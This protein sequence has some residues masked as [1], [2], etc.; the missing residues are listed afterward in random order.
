MRPGDYDL[1][2]GRHV[3]V[4]LLAASPVTLESQ[5]TGFSAKFVNDEIQEAAPGTPKKLGQGDGRLHRTCH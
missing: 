5:A 3:G 4:S 1:Q 2:P